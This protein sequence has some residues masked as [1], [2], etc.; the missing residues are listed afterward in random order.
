MPWNV[1][2][3]QFVMRF[4]IVSHFSRFLVGIIHFLL[5]PERQVL[6]A[7]KCTKEVPT[8]TVCIVFLSF[9]PNIVFFFWEKKI[10]NITS[11][12]DYPENK[13]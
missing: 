2:N 11:S 7:D 6:F 8:L 10:M 13:G 4:L 9:S 12:L 5:L 1:T 3:L